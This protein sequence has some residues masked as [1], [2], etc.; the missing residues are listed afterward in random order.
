MS[1]FDDQ[2]R[3]D[4]AVVPHQHMICTRCRKVSDLWP[5]QAPLA[6]PPEEAWGWGRVDRCEVIYRGV[7]RECLNKE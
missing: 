6:G 4:A 1:A 2:A 5:G 7:C 3:F